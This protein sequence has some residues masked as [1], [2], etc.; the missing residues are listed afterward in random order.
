MGQGGRGGREEEQG[1]RVMACEGGNTSTAG[2]AAK[3][4]KRAK[5]NRKVLGGAVP[6]LLPQMRRGAGPTL[7]VFQPPGRKRGNWLMLTAKMKTTFRKKFW[8]VG[9]R[10][11]RR[12]GAGGTAGLSPACGWGVLLGKGS[13]RGGKSAKPGE[14]LM[15]WPCH[16]FTFAEALTSL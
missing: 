9:R 4:I 2:P 11:G 14:V 15:P 7:L 12:V 5:T 13:L 3:K 6:L 8:N 10:H 16:S 1:S